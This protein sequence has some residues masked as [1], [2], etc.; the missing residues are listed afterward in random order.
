MGPG[1]S[2]YAYAVSGAHVYEKSFFTKSDMDKL[3]TAPSYDA[4]VSMLAD[5][6]WPMPD[7]TRDIGKILDME[8][9]RA[10]GWILESAPDPKVFHALILRNDFHN[11]KAGIKCL[12][13]DFDVDLHFVTPSNIDPQLMKEAIETHD[14]EKLPEPFASLGKEVYDL[15]VRTGDGQLADI[16][17]DRKCLYEIS[18]AANATGIDL[19]KEEMEIYTATTNIKTAFRAIKTGK[20]SDFLER[21]LS[22]GCT[23]VSKEKLV[24]CAASEKK[25]EDLLSYLDSTSYRSGTKYLSSS[26]A[27]YEKWVDDK[28]ISLLLP[29]RH[30][31]L[32]PEPLIGFYLGKEAEVRNARIIMA[33]KQ[34]DLP[35]DVVAKRLRRL[36]E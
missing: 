12:L 35:L 9:A 7:D 34:N 25:M 21:A 20:D 31:P 16:Q 27:E 26:P 6:G 14:F 32:G 19:L 18:K 36:Y 8:L 22:D 29:T 15:L 11:L 10:W 24:S 23:T 1:V 17:I 28:M 33:A 3:L 13:S 4:V 5:R 30:S 2:K